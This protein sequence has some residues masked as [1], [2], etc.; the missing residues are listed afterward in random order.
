MQVFAS[1]LGH[2]QGEIYMNRIRSKFKLPDELVGK[3]I[4]IIGTYPGVGKS[5]IKND[6]AAKLKLQGF[7]VK[8]LGTTQKASIDR[9]VSAL[10]EY[11]FKKDENRE[12][13]SDERILKE[14]ENTHAFIFVDEAWFYNQKQIN[15]VKEKYPIL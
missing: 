15:E 12:R 6:W 8:N 14:H 4:G 7:K 3:T 11:K 10:Y 1:T 2:L 9:T 13:E 5:H